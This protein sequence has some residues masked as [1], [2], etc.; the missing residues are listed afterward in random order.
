MTSQ[1]LPSSLCHTDP[2]LGASQA[3]EVCR[4]PRRPCPSG[5]WQATQLAKEARPRCRELLLPHLDCIVLPHRQPIRAS[6]GSAHVLLFAT[7]IASCHSPLLEHAEPR[8]CRGGVAWGDAAEGEGR[9][10]EPRAP[11]AS[12]HPPTPGSPP[13]H[14]RC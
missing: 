8:A 3:H 10:P 7:D 6:P 11:A 14:I 13:S 1:I 5:G 12:T 2:A 4:T 9:P